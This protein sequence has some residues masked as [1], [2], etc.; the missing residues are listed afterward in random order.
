MTAHRKVRTRARPL[1]V[2]GWLVAVCGVLTV[3][4]V[5]VGVGAIFFGLHHF[6]RGLPEYSQLEDYEPPTLTRLH[7]GDGRLLA[8]Y[9]QEQRVFVPIETIPE[10]LIRAFVAAEDKNF[11]SHKGVDFGGIARA[12]IKNLINIG[13]GR[14]LIGASTITQQVAKNFLL[15]NEVS[16]D[17]KI[18]EAIL[19]IRIE[20]ALSKERILELYLNEIFLGQRSY[21]VAAAAIN[22]FDK[23]LDNL[24]LAQIAFLAGLPKAP[25]TYHPERNM[26]AALGRRSY[27]LGRMFEDNYIDKGELVAANRSHIKLSPRK[28][29]EIVEAPFFAEEVRRQINAKYGQDALYKGGLSVRTTV[30]PNLQQVGILALRDGLVSYDRRYGWRGP[31]SELDIDGDWINQLMKVQKPPGIGD[32][33]LSVILYISE[34]Q[35]TIG[36]P[37]GTKGSIPLST[38]AWARQAKGGYSLGPV[39]ADVRDVFSP[40]DVVMVEAILSGADGNQGSL[41]KY[42]LCQ[43][44]E[45]EGALVA[46]DPHTGRV[47]AMVGG[48][49]FGESQFNRATQ[50]MRQP[51]SAF[52]P[53]VYIAAIESGY[54]PS[55]LILDAP[56]V[57]DQGPELGMW[58]PENYGRDFGGPATMRVGIEKSKN[59]MTVRLANTI[60]MERVL[61]A[62]SRFG[63]GNFE[64]NLSTALGSGET[65]LLRLTTAYAM[66]VN[67]GKKIKPSLIERIQDRNGV[68]IESRDNRECPRCLFPYAT[69]DSLPR[70]SDFREEVTDP[71]TAF[72]LTWMLKGVVERGTA[73]RVGMLGRPLGG[74][75]GTTNDSLDAWFIGFSPDLAVGVYIGFDKPRSLGPKQTGSNVAAP[76]FKQFMEG[77]MR[78]RPAVPFRIPNGIRMVRIDADSGAL[79]GPTS[80]RTILEAFKPGNEPTDSAVHYHGTEG[81]LRYMNDVP[82]GEEEGLY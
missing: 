50:A 65:T 6:S 75:T 73:R 70:L 79:P 33:K 38:L 43:L 60:G 7:A 20:R 8:E 39:I 19:A 55:S 78:G 71:A 41:P 64:P 80:K 58:K 66:L 53:F 24:N 56:F 25:N 42:D 16:L 22:Y 49:S 13:S 34:S 21:G 51:G 54:S 31:L 40:G 52:K 29:S 26:A 5:L 45:V 10:L 32:W 9:A 30:D 46:I 11:Y 27:V 76:V 62:A 59:L 77:A 17:R 1:R 18:R 12:I 67:G 47:L 57:V 4:S 15:T 37:D 44:P 81:N 35:A 14:R 63:L 36:L 2:L 3:V 23:A 72:Q 82:L 74:K 28:L 48:W 68:T 69:S 61:D